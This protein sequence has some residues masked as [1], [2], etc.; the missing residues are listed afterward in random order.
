M[1]TRY[2]ESSFAVVSRSASPYSLDRIILLWNINSVEWEI[3]FTDTFAEWW[4]ALDEYEQED[5][6]ASVKLL[7]E[8]GPALGRPHVDLVMTSAYREHEGVAHAA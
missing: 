5:V 6:T 8:R 3:E 4:D 1:R 2:H 7:R